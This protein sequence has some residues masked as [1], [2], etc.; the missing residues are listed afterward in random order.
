MEKI[1]LRTKFAIETKTKFNIEF[2]TH[3]DYVEWLEG[4]L[5]KLLTIPDLS[6]SLERAK[7]YARHQHYRGSMNKPLVEFEDWQAKD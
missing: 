2:V 7:K 5:I 6:I 3:N 1:D 4:K